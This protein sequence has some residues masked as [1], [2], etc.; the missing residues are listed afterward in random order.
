MKYEIEKGIPLPPK[1]K[2]PGRPRI[3]PFAD[4]E[5]GDSVYIDGDIQKIERARIAAHC[6][7]SRNCMS[8]MIENER[9]GIRIWR[10]A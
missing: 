3:Y 5:V 6:T 7:G 8:F 4:M 1:K 2:S 9:D 10:A